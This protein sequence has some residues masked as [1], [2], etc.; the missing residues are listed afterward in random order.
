VSHFVPIIAHEIDS[1]FVWWDEA[2]MF[3]VPIVLGILGVLS[4]A[5]RARTEDIEDD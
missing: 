1:G 3:A 5:R 4:I 2:V